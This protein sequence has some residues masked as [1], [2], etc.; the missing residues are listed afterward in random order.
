MIA[1]EGSRL[2]RSKLDKPS[3]LTVLDSKADF[4]APASEIGVTDDELILGFVLWTSTHL[5]RYITF[6]SNFSP[7]QTVETNLLKHGA[8]H[9]RSDPA[10]SERTPVIHGLVFES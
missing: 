6:A 5:D 3:T 4:A 1:R 8:C 2:G 7:E 10:P 9:C